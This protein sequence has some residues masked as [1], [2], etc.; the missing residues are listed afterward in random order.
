ML[1]TDGRLCQCGS[2]YYVTKEDSCSLCSAVISE[3]MACAWSVG[4]GSVLCSTCGEGKVLS[5]DGRSCESGSSS[6]IIVVSCLVGVAVLI[7]GGTWLL[8]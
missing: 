6:T 4:S 1:S 7:G 3:C 5:V 8:I 2:Q